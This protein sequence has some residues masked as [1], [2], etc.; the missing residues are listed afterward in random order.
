MRNIFFAMGLLLIISMSGCNFG[1]NKPQ[2]K[3]NKNSAISANP[4]SNT[5]VAAGEFLVLDGAGKTIEKGSLTAASDPDVKIEVQG[6]IITLADKSST[7]VA[8]IEPRDGGY[9]IKDSAGKYL[10]K[11]KPDGSDCKI[12]D[13]AGTKIGKA[14]LKGDKILV[15]NAKGETIYQIFGIKSTQAAAVWIINNW[16]EK[17]KTAVM[18]A[19]I[20]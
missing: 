13:E 19:L 20:K 5:K 14:K 10:A 4:T 8:T 1:G 6:T 16:S 15:E 17:Q 2:V 18:L 11:L 9:R 12:G 7:K 3:E